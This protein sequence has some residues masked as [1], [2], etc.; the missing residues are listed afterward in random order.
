M[1]NLTIHS[2]LAAAHNYKCFVGQQAQLVR[3][4]T[5]PLAGPCQR[6]C[7]AHRQRAVTTRGYGPSGTMVTSS[8]AK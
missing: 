4:M 5:R 8:P 6:A 2:G 1:K 3:P 7:L